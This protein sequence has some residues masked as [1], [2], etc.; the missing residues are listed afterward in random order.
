MEEK[1]KIQQSSNDFEMSS[2]F[3]P[4][5]RMNNFQLGGKHKEA[6]STLVESVPGINNL[7]WFHEFFEIGRDYNI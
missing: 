5:P 2:L 4:L 6:I 1:R 7:H 3:V